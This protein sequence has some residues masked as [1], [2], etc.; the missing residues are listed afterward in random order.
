M[1]EAEDLNIRAASREDCGTIL[2]FI[3]ALADYEKLLHEVVATETGLKHTLFGERPGAEVLIAEWRG[4][5]AGFALFFHNYST[6]LGQPGIYLEDL[7][8][9]PQFRGHGIGKSLLQ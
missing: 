6:F 7:F 1:S 2:H 4:E 8:V 5:P 9:H 3:R